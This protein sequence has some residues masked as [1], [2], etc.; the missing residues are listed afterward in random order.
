HFKRIEGA[1]VRMNR[2][3]A[4]LEQMNSPA[5]LE[6]GVGPGAYREPADHRRGAIVPT[7]AMA[8]AGIQGPGRVPR[9]IMAAP[10]IVGLNIIRVVE[11]VVQPL[12]GMGEY[13]VGRHVDVAQF[14]LRLVRVDYLG[15][16]VVEEQ[17]LQGLF[18]G[19]AEA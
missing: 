10:A 19:G 1:V 16:R 14:V 11:A 17:V 5:E 4:V 3:R 6:E 7:Q 9:V 12:R 15:V 13:F 2:G 18:G 8:T